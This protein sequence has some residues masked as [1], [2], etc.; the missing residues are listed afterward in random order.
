MIHKDTIKQF[1]K[2]NKE[3]LLIFLILFS[4]LFLLIPF[5]VSC[6]EQSARLNKR[7]GTCVFVN[8]LGWKFFEFSEYWYLSAF[9]HIQNFLLI[10]TLVISYFLSCL[11][12][13]GYNKFK[14]R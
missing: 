4:I 10:F 14:T 2:P 9:Y 1:L 3:K 12:I 13:F 11:I 8:Y 6:P 5:D 7:G